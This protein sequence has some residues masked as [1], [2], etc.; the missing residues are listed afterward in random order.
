MG[1]I[2]QKVLFFGLFGGEEAFIWVLYHNCETISKLLSGSTTDASSANNGFVRYYTCSIVFALKWLRFGLILYAGFC[3]YGN[4]S[5]FLP[6][7]WPASR[8]FLFCCSLGAFIM[9]LLLIPHSLMFRL[10]S[11]LQTNDYI[12]PVFSFKW[13]RFMSELSWLS[14]TVTKLVCGLLMLPGRS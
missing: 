3:E 2:T 11:T 14:H 6:L 4:S 5:P 9:S 1:R 13:I 7:T 8:V 12:G 10:F